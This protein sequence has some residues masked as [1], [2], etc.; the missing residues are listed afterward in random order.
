[1][2]GEYTPLSA[3][4]ILTKDLEELRLTVREMRERGEEA[5]GDDGGGGAGGEAAG[6]DFL[7]TGGSS[8]CWACTGWRMGPCSPSVQRAGLGWA[9]VPG[10]AAACVGTGMHT[11]EGVLLLL[12]CK[13]L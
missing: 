10:L 1:M 9:G 7:A 11:V 8:G 4:D 6:E 2:Y 3:R 13:R 12:Q 5:G